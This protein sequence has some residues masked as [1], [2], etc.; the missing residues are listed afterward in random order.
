MGMRRDDLAIDTEPLDAG[1]ARWSERLAEAASDYE[2]IGTEA[3]AG[4]G[5]DQC[6]G[7]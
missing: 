3:I 7:T 2:T 4:L 5:C 6:Q 1:Q